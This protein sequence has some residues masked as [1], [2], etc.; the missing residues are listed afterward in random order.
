[1]LAL[2]PWSGYP[3]DP[4]PS[5]SCP[6]LA[7][8]IIK[9]RKVVEKSSRRVSIPGCG[10]RLLLMQSTA[11]QRML[12]LR[13]GLLIMGSHRI[14]HVAIGHPGRRLINQ[15]PTTCRPVTPR[16]Y[17]YIFLGE[18]KPLLT[19]FPFFNICYFGFVLFL[20][21]ELLKMATISCTV[22]TKNS[23]RNPHQIRITSPIPKWRSRRW[24]LN[25]NTLFM[26]LLSPVGYMYIHV[27]KRLLFV[28]TLRENL[29]NTLDHSPF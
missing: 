12:T 25:I 14:L 20:V 11:H 18:W 16:V 7:I 24:W 1:M 19:P 2:V 23:I 6:V 26:A 5:H 17:Y 8:F 28:Y 21:A 10:R 29:W 9:M 15:T 22:G 13:G 3:T 4:I 27:T